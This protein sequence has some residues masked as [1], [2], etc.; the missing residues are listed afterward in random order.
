MNRRDMIK[1]MSLAAAG[2]GLAR[3]PLACAEAADKPKR[4][5]LFFTKCSGFIHPVVKRT[6]D[7]LAFAEKVLTEF[8][9]PQGYEVVCSKDGSLFTPE[10]LAK[11]DAYLFYTSGDLTQPGTDKQPPM[12]PEGKTAFLD[13]IAGGKGYIGFH[14]AN[15]SFH[16]PG[17]R[18]KNSETLDPYIAM[19]GGEFIVH[20]AQQKAKMICCDP[21]FPGMAEVGEG[22]EWLE[23]WYALKNFAKDLHVILAQDTS[24]MKDWCYQRPPFPA[25]W[26]RRHGKGRVYYTSL[27][28]REDIWT[29]PLF[30]KI[31][32]GA[33]AWACGDAEADLTPNI[34]KVTPKCA[35]LPV[36]GPPPRPAKKA[37]PKKK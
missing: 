19:V 20:G 35:E 29:N 25:T 28:H 18:N 23:E 5:L 2:L 17:D 7:Q 21:K 34:D 14:S 36:G 1:R 31:V 12:T 30:Q 33:I 32:L 37:A 11:F 27:G 16:S 3:F 26:A 6:D 9:T 22:F 24:T 4:R 13:A 10:Y 15:D 8:C